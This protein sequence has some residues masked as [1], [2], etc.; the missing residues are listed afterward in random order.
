MHRISETL[1]RPRFKTYMDQSPV[2]SGYIKMTELL[3]EDH[4]WFVI[5]KDFVIEE[6]L[7]KM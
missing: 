3:L 2:E 6:P 5:S 7:I 1:K 4:E